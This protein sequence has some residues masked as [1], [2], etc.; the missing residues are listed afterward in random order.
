MYS[1]MPSPKSS[2]VNP[3][4]VELLNILFTKMNPQDVLEVFWGDDVP[5]G[6][7]PPLVLYIL[8]YAGIVRRGSRSVPSV[9]FG[10]YPRY[11]K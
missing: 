4:L 7:P 8:E 9:G 5:D 2:S 6:L 11:Q 1:G 3:P 10:V